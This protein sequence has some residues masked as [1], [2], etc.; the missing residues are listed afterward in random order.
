MSSID[1]DSDPELI[2]IRNE[3]IESFLARRDGFAAFAAEVERGS[4]VI[5]EFRVAAHK[6]AG[7]AES[8]GFP[9]LTT[10]G[11]LVDEL[12]TAIIG[13]GSGPGPSDLASLASLLAEALAAAHATRT[14]PRAFGRDPRVE[15]LREWVSRTG[16]RSTNGSS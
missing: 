15:K 2:R 8:Y 10:I 7:A 9:T 13:G 14:D 12:L 11:E 6:L 3:F 5:P 16:S 1:W 4:D